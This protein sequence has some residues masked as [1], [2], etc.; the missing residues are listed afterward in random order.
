MKMFCFLV[1]GI[2]TTGISL[3]A[4]D[5][6]DVAATTQPPSGTPS[7]MGRTQAGTSYSYVGS[8]HGKQDG[9]GRIGMGTAELIAPEKI[10][11]IDDGGAKDCPGE[12]DPDGR[13]DS[14]LAPG[15][16]RPDAL[17]T[18][19]VQDSAAPQ[20]ATVRHFSAADVFDYRQPVIFRDGF[21][22][23]QFGK[24]RFSEN[25]NYEI[26]HQDPERIKIVEAPGLGS[27]RKAVRF[28]VPRAPNSF[29][30]EI[31]LPHEKGFQE[32]WYGE[33]ILV[34]GDWVVDPARGNDI[35]MQWH[36]IPGNWRATYPNLAISIGNTNWFIR[37]SFGSAQTKPTRTTCKLVDPVQP[38]SWVSWV[39]HAKWS[40]DTDGLLRIWKDG[41]LVVDLKG[42]NV[43]STIGVEYTPYLKTG[44]Y[45]PEW[46]L[47]KDNMREAFDKEKSTTTNKIIYATD[48]KIGDARAQ[49]KDV[50][51][52]P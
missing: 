27:K 44:I 49:Y 40:P 26:S 19:R 42:P 47:T 20:A 9:S 48:I 6:G 12:D 23:E 30:S 36:A 22:S 1:I 45:H 41:T 3:L 16:A 7:S 43:Y 17:H 2:A 24:W 5:G 37:Q 31:S 21:Q 39:I 13:S 34:P 10:A 11:V 29:R 14:A 51:P 25:D 33:R 4:A 28:S 50:V 46:H 35:V 18:A 8:W 32:R 52:T 38:G 15:V